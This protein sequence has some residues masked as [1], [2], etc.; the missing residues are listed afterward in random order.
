MLEASPSWGAAG[1]EIS[2]TSEAIHQEVAFH[3]SPKRVYDT[4]TDA[5]QFD[6]VIKLS[7]AV[8]SGMALGDKPT[9]IGREVGSAFTIYFGHI[10]G[11]QLELVPSARIVQA[12]RVVDWDP[13][14]Y[15]IAKFVITE[16]GSGAKLVFDHTGFPNGQAQHL[17]EGWHSNYWE[18][19]QKYLAIK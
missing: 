18:P 8:A 14:I 2:R 5:A 17:A 11:L 12:W 16:Q 4:L 7:A 3:A 15:S 10:V 1:D 9:K 6:K 19:M 13:G